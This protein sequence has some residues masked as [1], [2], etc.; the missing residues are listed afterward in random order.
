MREIL[1][2][3]RTLITKVIEHIVFKSLLINIGEPRISDK[4]LCF[5]FSKLQALMMVVIEQWRSLPGIVFYPERFTGQ[6]FFSVLINDFN[7]L[8]FGYVPLDQ[9]ISNRCVFWLAF[10]IVPPQMPLI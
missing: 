10:A 5:P 6:C 3:F 7:D 9:H 8:H 4:G 1:W 2:R